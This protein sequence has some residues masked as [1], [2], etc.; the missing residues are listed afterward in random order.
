[1]CAD[2]ASILAAGYTCVLLYT[3]MCEA[4]L[5][6]PSQ[7]LLGTQQILL[8]L[9]WEVIAICCSVLTLFILTSL[10]CFFVCLLFSCLVFLQYTSSMRAKYLATNQPRPDAGSVH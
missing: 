5:V 8:M 9:C 2:L 1:M 4:L 3:V 7:Q 10:F 6:R